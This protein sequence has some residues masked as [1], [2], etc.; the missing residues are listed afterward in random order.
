MKPAREKLRR[1]RFLQAGATA[2]LGGASVACTRNTSPWRFFTV[3][4][5]ATLEAMCDQIVPADQDPGA[6]DAGAVN[7]IDRQLMGHYKPHRQAYRTGIAA[8]NRTSRALHGAAFAELP[9]EKRVAV[10]TAMDKNQAPPD[11]WPDAGAAK[12]FFDLVVTHTMQGFYGSPRHG[13]NRE[14][15]SWRMLGV[16]PLPVR[17]RLHWDIRKG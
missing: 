10:L 5:A 17:G 3:E 15:V 1:R 9:V 8:V 2:A 14:A 13:G 4:E 16:P 11:A 6:A 12:A 7:F